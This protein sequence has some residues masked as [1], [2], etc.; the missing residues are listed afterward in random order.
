M[1]GLGMKRVGNLVDDF[2]IENIIQAY[3]V[4]RKNTLNKNKIYKF[5]E[6]YTSNISHVFKLLNDYKVGKYNIFL[7]KDPKYRIIMSQNINDKII[8]HLMADILIKVLEPSLIRANVASRKGKGT[9]YGIKCLKKYLNSMNGEVYALKFDISKFFYN[10]DHNVL[11]RMLKRKIKDKKYLDILFK[12]IDSTDSDY[13]NESIIKLKEKEINYLKN[14]NLN[15]KDKRIDEIN[16]IPL[17]KKGKGLGIGNVVS[18]I[19]AIFYLNDLDHFIKEKL[20]I[21]YYIRYQDDGI[22]LEYDKEYLKYCLD[23]INKFVLDYGLCLNDKTRIINVS[24]EGADFIGF[25][26]YIKNKI[27]LKVRNNTKKRFKK[28]MKL[29]KKGKIKNGKNVVASYKGHF[30]LG[31]CYYLFKKFDFKKILS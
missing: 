16:R 9:S 30:K 28:K 22:L 29:I 3:K 27:I 13:V 17:Y 10:I 18:Q 11:K 20:H 31:N 6:Y 14:S 23:E 25:R 8:N 19:L 26:F 24:K 4:V 7:I 2:T 15:D 5:E 1:G 12:I 21:K